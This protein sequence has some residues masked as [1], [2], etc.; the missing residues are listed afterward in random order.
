MTARSPPPPRPPAT[1]PQAIMHLG[2]DFDTG[3]DRVLSV[4]HQHDA[5]LCARSR[6]EHVE[7]TPRSAP[8]PRALT[9]APRRSTLPEFDYL[10]SQLEDFTIERPMYSSR[11]YTTNY[12]RTC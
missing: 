7:I 10:V 2:F 9:P 6:R 4:L 3:M 1:W 11:F 5:D 12:H 8:L